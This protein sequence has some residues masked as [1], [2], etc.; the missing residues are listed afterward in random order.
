MRRLLATILV[1][2]CLCAAACGSEGTET[3]PVWFLTE[4]G[5]LAD[6]PREVGGGTAAEQATAALEALASG[7]ES[8]ELVAVVPPGT[9]AE[10]S[11]S[12]ATATVDLAGGF[13]ASVSAAG[14]AAALQ[15]VAPLVWTVTGID[16]IDDVLLREDGAPLELSGSGLVF[17]EPL[18]REDFPEAGA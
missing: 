3:A 2:A 8:A 4:T 6:E 10:V 9:T 13:A 12:D 18:G 5:T 17:D 14:S 16:G 1:F 15:I 7:P 11:V